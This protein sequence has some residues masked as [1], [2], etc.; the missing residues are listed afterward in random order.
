[1]DVPMIEGQGSFTAGLTD[2]DPHPAPGQVRQ[3]GVCSQQ[4]K[5]AAITVQVKLEKVG[6]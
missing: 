5:F 1:M 4:V 3:A 2:F 6:G